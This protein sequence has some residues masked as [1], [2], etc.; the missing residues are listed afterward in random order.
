MSEKKTHTHQKPKE[1]ETM[2]LIRC[3]LKIQNRKLEQRKCLMRQ[4]FGND[5]SYLSP[6]RSSR[7]RE[8]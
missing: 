6:N 4:R 8:G 1:N 2:Q 7:D 3:K 5:N